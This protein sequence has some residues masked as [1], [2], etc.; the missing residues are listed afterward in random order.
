MKPEYLLIGVVALVAAAYF[1]L[2]KKSAGLTNP[3]QLSTTGTK[4]LYDPNGKYMYGGDMNGIPY[5]TMPDGS[6][7][8]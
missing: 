2:S 8:Y 5:R 6:V 7:V 3:T 1:V 4:S